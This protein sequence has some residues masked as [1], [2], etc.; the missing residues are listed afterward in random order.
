M[1][2]CRSIRDGKSMYTAALV[3]SIS[4][5]VYPELDINCRLWWALFYLGEIH[6]F[7]EIHLPGDQSTLTFVTNTFL[8]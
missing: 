1:I 4:C 7:D 3:F 6:G 5:S 2:N 8:Q